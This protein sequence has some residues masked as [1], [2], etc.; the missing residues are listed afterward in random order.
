MGNIG[1][2][3]TSRE[4]HGCIL[5]EHISI[6]GPLF[7][8]R[9]ERGHATQQVVS[10]AEIDQSVK[11]KNGSLVTKGLPFILQIFSASKTDM[12]L[13]L[14]ERLKDRGHDACAVET[15]I[16]I[17]DLRLGLLHPFIG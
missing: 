15:G 4:N 10:L 11:Q 13:L 6:Q 1:Y 8:M 12:R 5:D 7:R 2:D 14:S 9:Y 16:G 17:H 3:K